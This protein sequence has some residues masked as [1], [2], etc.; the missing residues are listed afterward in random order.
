MNVSGWKIV[1][2]KMY[3]ASWKASRMLLKAFRSTIL[4]ETLGRLWSLS[5]A[6]VVAFDVKAR[7]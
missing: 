7:T 5:A 6:G 1:F 4:T 3:E 2:A